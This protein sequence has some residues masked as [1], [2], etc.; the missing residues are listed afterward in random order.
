MLQDKYLVYLN[1]TATGAAALPQWGK[2]VDHNPENKPNLQVSYPTSPPHIVNTNDIIVMS[3][4][5]K[6]MLIKFIDYL[7]AFTRVELADQ[8]SPLLIYDI[9]L[10]KYTP[11]PPYAT[12][13]NI[14]LLEEIDIVLSNNTVDISDNNVVKKF[15]KL[16]QRK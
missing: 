13:N 15:F 2:H 1:A 5:H 4:I 10:E 6:G 14:R 11:K 9:A 3:T 8:L 12:K 7:A 16:F